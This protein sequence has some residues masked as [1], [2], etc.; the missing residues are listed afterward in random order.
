MIA[1]AAGAGLPDGAV[2][3]T[4]GWFH[5]ADEADVV[6]F[7]RAARAARRRV[8]VRGAHH[9][10]P[11]AVAG[12]RDIVLV[13][14]RF[15]HIDIDTRTWEVSAGAG[16]RLGVDPL[17]PRAASD[18]T[19]CPALHAAGRA[20]PNLGGIVHQT[21]AGFLATGSAGGSTRFDAAASVVGL[22]FVDGHGDVHRLR[23]ENDAELLDA[24][25]VAVGFVRHRHRSDVRDGAGVRREWDRNGPSRSRRRRGSL[26]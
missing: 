12:P 2:A 17:N 24:V 19:L 4:H 21:V 11:S 18:A 22:R 13:L 14:D 8:R 20:L 26:R 10:V 7:V 1:I 6:R 15:R 23:R 5:P 9:S 3:D 25:L 16:L